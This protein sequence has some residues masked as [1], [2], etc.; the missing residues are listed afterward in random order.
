MRRRGRA[1]RRSF[2]RKVGKWPDSYCLIT[3]LGSRPN[4][5]ECLK[6]GEERVVAD[7]HLDPDNDE[8]VLRT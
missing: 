6:D 4:E 8:I 3:A 2:V 5:H 7:V 1:K